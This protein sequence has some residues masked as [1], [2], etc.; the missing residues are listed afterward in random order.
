MKS[1]LFLL[2][3]YKHYEMLHKTELDSWS[4]QSF[5]NLNNKYIMPPTLSSYVHCPQITT[6]N[7]FLIS[8][9]VNIKNYIL[10][11]KYGAVKT[12]M[13]VKNVII[14]WDIYLE[15]ETIP[16][17]DSFITFENIVLYN[18]HSGPLQVPVMRPLN[19][20]VSHHHVGQKY[21]IYYFGLSYIKESCKKLKTKI[22]IHSILFSNN[23]V[24]YHKLEIVYIL[25]MIS[26][27]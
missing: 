13:K 15:E 18:V 3:C 19:C 22:I 9:A 5:Y 23:Y 25:F 11:S 24:E 16:G 4:L 8:E 26:F 14:F 20:L 7:S 12:F 1:S 6:L 17:T 2:F 21:Q 27:I 10:S